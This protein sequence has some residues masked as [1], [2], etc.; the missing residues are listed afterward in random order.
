MH[1]FEIELSQGNCVFNQKMGVLLENYICRAHKS[2]PL[3]KQACTIW[4]HLEPS[5]ALAIGAIRSFNLSQ[6]ILAAYLK[7][8]PTLML[9]ATY[10]ES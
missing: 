9:C 6:A 10:F 5:I 2:T 7:N 3:K 8:I 4:C 1:F